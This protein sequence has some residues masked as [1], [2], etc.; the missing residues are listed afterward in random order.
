[1]HGECKKLSGGRS[2][3]KKL[4]NTYQWMM[5]MK[6]MANKLNGL[7]LL[8]MKLTVVKSGHHQFILAYDSDNLLIW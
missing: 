3:D 5:R 4:V 1:M 2:N 6:S 7:R 8:L